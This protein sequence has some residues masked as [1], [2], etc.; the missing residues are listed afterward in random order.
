MKTP[1][2]ITLVRGETVGVYNP[3]TSQ[4][5]YPET[6]KTTVPCLVNFISRATV[7][8]EYGE[9]QDNIMICRF[10][11]EQT[12]FQSAIYDDR[13]FKPLDKIDAPIKDA[14]RL[15]EVLQDAN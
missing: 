9:V 3:E 6:D 8:R 14:V 13:T 1:H 4:I 7:L 5:E 12:P 2:R 10:P 11:Q 15:K